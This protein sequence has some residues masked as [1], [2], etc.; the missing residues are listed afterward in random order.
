MNDHNNL[1]GVPNSDACAVRTNGRE[2][3]PSPVP[4]STAPTTAPTTNDHRR[5]GAPRGNA[6]R[7]RHGLRGTKLPPAAKAEERKLETFR[8]WLRETLQADGRTIDLATAATMQA[9][10]RHERGALLAL[11]W[12]RVEH[13][14]LSLAERLQ[15]LET[16]AR[17]TTARDKALA[18]LGL[19]INASDDGGSDLWA[20]LRQSAP[21]P[22]ASDASPDAIK[23]AAPPVD[24]APRLAEKPTSDDSDDSEQTFGGT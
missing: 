16:I 11:R 12:L 20:S 18:R 9:C 22:H 5:G 10:E 21:T 4:S 2:T 7:T 14:K 23:D 24:A 1:T 3:P 15:L 19:R 8:G 17:A 6:N 13:D